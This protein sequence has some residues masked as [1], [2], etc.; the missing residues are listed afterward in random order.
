VL[1]LIAATITR[2][3]QT[4]ATDSGVRQWVGAAHAALAFLG[5]V[6]A[7]VLLCGL[8]ESRNLPYLADI[9]AVLAHRGV[10]AYTFSMSRFFDLTGPSFAALRLPALLAAVTFA[11]GPAIAWTLRG[12]RRHLAATTSIALTAGGFLFAAHIALARFAPMLSSKNLAERIEQ[13]EQSGRILPGTEILLFG[14][15]AYGSS[16]SFYLGRPVYLVN[17]RSS[18]M[19]FG[20]TFPDCPPIF[21]NGPQLLAGWGSGTR[22]IVFVP[23]ESRAE[24]ESLLGRNQIVIA[25]SSG[26]AL[27]TDRPLEVSR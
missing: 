24:F 18:S 14:D 13:M 10:G 19:L 15:Q 12:Q 3:E 11:F 7:V 20:S 17:G 16:I 27:F 2:A 21:I 22:K 25:E 26:K 8:W 9:G 23:L 6:I 5:A 4:F 1:L